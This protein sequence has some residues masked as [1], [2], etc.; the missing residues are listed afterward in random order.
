[1]SGN[2]IAPRGNGSAADTPADQ[3]LVKQLTWPEPDTTRPAI[4][5]HLLAQL[6][7]AMESVPA[8]NE[9]GSA[10]ILETLLRATTIDDLNKPWNGTSGRE[11]AGR[12]L[13]VRG[14]IR[15]PSQFEDGPAVFLV[16][17]CADVKT[18]EEVTMTTSALACIVQLAMAHKLGMFPLMVE[19]VV[20]ERPTDR[21]YYPYHLQV[22]A[23]GNA[24][25]PRQSVP[26]F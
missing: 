20:A 15:R 14:I 26:E 24:V 19:V 4:P 13:S 8:E 1:M 6:V 5:E 2:E 17:N 7:D 10:A 25:G 23:A 18:G 11:L 21:G 22:I 16:A 3:L 12:R 9:G